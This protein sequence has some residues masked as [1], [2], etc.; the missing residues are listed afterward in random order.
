[1][2]IDSGQIWS[3]LRSLVIILVAVYGSVLVLMFIF[4]SKL[5]YFPERDI[6]AAPSDVGLS[7]EDI[8]FTTDDGISINGW[9]IPGDAGES[10]I[11][12][13]HGNAGN[14][15][16]R[17]ESIGF[18][19]K[20]NFN[21]LIFDYRGYGRSEGAPSEKGTYKDASAAWDYLTKQKNIA[22]GE[23]IMFGRSLG[24]AIAVH[25]ASEKPVGGLIV[26]SSFTSVG[27]LGS[28]IYPFLPVRLLSRFKY[29]VLKKIDKIDCPL[30]VIHSRDD[31]MIPFHHGKRL[32]EAA[33]EPKEFLEIAGDHNQGFWTTSENYEM[34]IDS[35]ISRVKQK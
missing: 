4:Q 10:T 21:V 8:Y 20:L 31:E 26:E 6:S 14:I 9:Y 25:L 22:P 28:E 30:L 1:M 24:G 34:A 11:L 18:F 19:H 15:S 16:H 29:E 7:Y 27:D 35:F 13:C 33:A 12:F 3:V 32:F 17:L 23:I 2:N 5:L